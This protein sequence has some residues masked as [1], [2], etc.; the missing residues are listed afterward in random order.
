MAINLE[1]IDK[2]EFRAEI[3]EIDKTSSIKDVTVLIG[4]DIL[5]KISKQKSVFNIH[6]GLRQL[7][8]SE[9]LF[10][11]QN[12]KNIE[13]MVLLNREISKR[14]EESI[15][16]R[17]YFVPLIKDKSNKRKSKLI[18]EMLK[19]QKDF[20]K[21][22]F[23]K[24]LDLSKELSEIQKKYNIAIASIKHLYFCSACKTFVNEL[25]EASMFYEKI[26]CPL[27]ATEINEKD[28]SNVPYLDKNI[29]DYLNG[30]WL[31][32]YMAKLFE[33][34]GYK[35]WPG[36]FVAGVS[37]I[38]HEIDLLAVNK[39]GYTLILEC[40]TTKRIEQNGNI[41]ARIK[42]K[43]DIFNLAIKNNDIKSNYAFLITLYELPKT[44]KESIS[45]LKKTPGLGYLDNLINKND[46]QVIRSIKKLIK[47]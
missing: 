33:S 39:D 43:E 3:E 45:F 12:V 44:A 6:K 27:C 23:N 32:N 26:K 21:K 37:G 10:L 9:N 38:N 18:E 17:D 8:N 14:I 22:T 4:K 7:I 13:K 19:Q 36:V 25:H 41:V 40:K 29:E 31:E 30:K 42:R 20:F 34:V 1:N 15:Q 24:I 28:I 2:K 35:V 16:R 5:L 11:K 46:A 47:S